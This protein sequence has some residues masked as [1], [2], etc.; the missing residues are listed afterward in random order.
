MMRAETTEGQMHIANQLG[1]NDW[2]S[3]EVGRS[4]IVGINCLVAA[5]AHRHCALNLYCADPCIGMRV[6][7]A[8]VF[9][10]KA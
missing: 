7:D 4:K 6:S 1:R 5:C 8:L 3:G 2:C 10:F 9:A